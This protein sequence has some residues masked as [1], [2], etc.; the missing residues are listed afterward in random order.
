MPTLSP[1]LYLSLALGA[2]LSTGHLVIDPPLSPPAVA[3]FVISGYA[4]SA[5]AALGVHQGR[6]DVEI[7]LG[8]LAR[9]QQSRQN[10]GPGYDTSG[11][12]LTAYEAD[13]R[14]RCWLT[15]SS[16]VS[17]YGEAG[18]AMIRWRT[19]QWRYSSTPYVCEGCNWAGGWVPSD[20]YRLAPQLGLGLGI[21]ISSKWTATVGA[22]QTLGYTGFSTLQ[23]VVGMR[24][25]F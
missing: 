20:G 1:E 14:A 21:A 11:Y 6:W 5:R 4:P 3:P 17:L 16:K 23:A 10:T 15:V 13:V 18:V 24:Y 7:G 22:T 25:T 8:P 19:E 12:N 9:W 2:S